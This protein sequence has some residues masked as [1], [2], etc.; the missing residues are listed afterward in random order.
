MDSSSQD[1]FKMLEAMAVEIEQFFTDVAKDVNSMVDAF[2]EVSE[3]I[4]DYMQNA[5]ETEVEQRI[6][7]LID[8][9][10]E[11]YLGIEIAVE[12]TMQPTINTVEPFLK[13]HPACVGC[14]HYHGQSYGGPMLVC[15]MHPYGWEEEKCPDWQSI[16]QD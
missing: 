4:A 15:G 8:P 16:W 5:F 6:S 1:F 12:E 13:D 11:A 14:R 3:E 10:L 7:Y 9:I 2:A